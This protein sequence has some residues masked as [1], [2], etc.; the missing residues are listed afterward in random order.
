MPLAPMPKKIVFISPGL[1][2]GGAEMMLFKLCSMLDKSFFS[3]TI[4]SL[5]TQG[6]IGPRIENMG[7]PVYSF[8]IQKNASSIIALCKLRQLIAN[9]KPDLIQGWMYHG[10]LAASLF[11]GQA[12]VLWGIRSSLDSLDYFPK[13]TK[14][15]ILLN[16]YFSRFSQ[17]IIYNSKISAF[18]H[19][20]FGFEGKD[21]IV[22]PNGFNA[23]L[24][25]AD[26]GLR[27]SFRRELGLDDGTILVGLIARYHPMKD[28][29]TFVK[30]AA[31]LLHECPNVHFLLVGHGVSTSNTKLCDLI[32]DMYLS[33]HFTLLGERNDIQRITAALDV[34]TSCSSWGEG[35]SNSIGE[36]MCCNIPCVVTD[37]GDSA[38]LVGQTGRV[39]LPRDPNALA[40]AWKSLV[41]LGSDGRHALGL[42]ARERII[43]HFSLDLIAAQ[44]TNLYLRLTNYSEY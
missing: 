44:Y 38:W 28:H 1:S 30:A 6:T 14:A 4:I 27:Y 32:R 35:F 21:S 19:K 25:C 15:V 8:G 31:I 5:S 36:A 33:N 41:Y 20:S 7:I 40:A 37:V 22:I 43:H 2:T 10:N 29:E 24:F 42:L 26:S 34:A 17:C 3:L 13:L 39:V 18:Q 12:P 16:K 23:N 11:L 9:L